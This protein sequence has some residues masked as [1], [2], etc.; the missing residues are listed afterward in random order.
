MKCL[1]FYVKCTLNHHHVQATPCSYCL[2]HVCVFKAHLTILEDSL[3]IQTIG[4][5]GLIICA[6]LQII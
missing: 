1:M 5:A 6:A 2:A 4:G 3:H